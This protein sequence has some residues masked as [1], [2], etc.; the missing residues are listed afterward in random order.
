ML[1][2]TRMPGHPSALHLVIVSSSS[3]SSACVRGVQRPWDKQVLRLKEVITRSRRIRCIRRCHK[4]L[5]QPL[6]G[7][8]VFDAIWSI[9]QIKTW[10][11][12]RRFLTLQ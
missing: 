4:A 11:D 1:S 5:T 12:W 9:D 2:S 7:R 8:P 3:I 10:V 6:F